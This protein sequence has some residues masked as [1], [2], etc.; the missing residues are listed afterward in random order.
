M[1]HICLLLSGAALLINGLALLGALPRRDAAVLSLV[2]GSVQ[3][4]M[5]VCY[6]GVT[7]SDASATAG[8]GTQLLGA[9]GMFLFG[10]TYVL[11]GLDFL[12]GLG[13][14]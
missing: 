4:G 1:T 14:R 11:V 3:L 6:L 5:G 9:A 7:Y 12:L 10:L 2:I 13:S 8:S